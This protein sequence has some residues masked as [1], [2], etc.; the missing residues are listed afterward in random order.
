MGVL[1]ALIL[2]Y[3]IEFLLWSSI[4]LNLSFIFSICYAVVKSMRFIE[5]KVLA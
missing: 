2:G 4:F 1:G 3:M 5:L